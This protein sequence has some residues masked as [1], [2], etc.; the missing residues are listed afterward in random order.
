[1]AHD[2]EEGARPRGPLELQAAPGQLEPGDT[3][4][5]RSVRRRGPGLR[6]PAGQSIRW[7]GRCL[8]AGSAPD[9]SAR[10]RRPSMGR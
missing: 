1:V 6:P 4:R 9:G 2:V 10:G 3:G 5:G 8:R 7:T